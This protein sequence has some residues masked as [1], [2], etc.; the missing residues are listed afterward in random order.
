MSGYKYV[1]LYL[2]ELTCKFS[3]L[4]E[5]LSNVAP[6][7]DNYVYLD[8]AVQKE[9]NKTLPFSEFPITFENKIT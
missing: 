6:L 4:V 3:L 5:F 2:S 7:K 9:I 1:T 8:L